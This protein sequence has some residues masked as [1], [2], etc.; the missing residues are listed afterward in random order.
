MN[1]ASYIHKY[2]IFKSCQIVADWGVPDRFSLNDASLEW[3]VPVWSI[4]YWEGGGLTLFCDRLDL[5]SWCGPCVEWIKVTVPRDC[6]YSLCASIGKHWAGTHRKNAEK[7]KGQN[8]RGHLGRGHIVM[9]SKKTVHCLL[10][11]IMTNL[12]TILYPT[13]ILYK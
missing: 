4:P 10:G 2:L 6:L 9:A 7:Y 5:H 11:K 1:Y 3:C 8:I 12:K 13:I